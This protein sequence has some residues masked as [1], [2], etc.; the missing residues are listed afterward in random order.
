[1]NPKEFAWVVEVDRLDAAV[2][3]HL[4]RAHRVVDYDS[5][6]VTGDRALAGHQA[7]AI[8]GLDIVPSPVQCYRVQDVEQI[9]A[10][11]P[12]ALPHSRAHHRRD[13]NAND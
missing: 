1:L 2:W 3:N 9:A 7:V 13:P 10:H 5:V 6:E 8:A 4:A 11:L 12:R